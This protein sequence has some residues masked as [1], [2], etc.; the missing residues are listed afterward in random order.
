MK[1]KSGTHINTT[2]WKTKG[3]KGIN[4]LTYLRISAGAQR[5]MYVHRLVAEALLRRR[6]K[7]NET[8]DH[9]N[10]D[11]TDC[12]PTNIMVLSWSDHAKVT[13]GRRR[14]EGLEGIAYEVVLDGKKVF[15]RE[16]GDE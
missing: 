11:E 3:S 5:G 1:T 10:Q 16:A 14:P 2:K 15:E 6:L 12:D 4:K 8:V 13:N 9:A 7:P